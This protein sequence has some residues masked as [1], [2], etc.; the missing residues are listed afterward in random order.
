M[1]MRASSVHSVPA[2]V[3][4]LGA[5]SAAARDAAAV[6][7]IGRLGGCG[8]LPLPAL[9]PTSAAATV[10]SVVGISRGFPFAA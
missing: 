2:L 9:L 5:V 6:L 8:D 1:R 7:L 3:S 4:R 10:L